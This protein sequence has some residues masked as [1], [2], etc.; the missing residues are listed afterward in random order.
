MTAVTLSE[1]FKKHH[2]LYEQLVNECSSVPEFKMTLDLYDKSL[3]KWDWIVFFNCLAKIPAEKSAMMFEDILNT[4]DSSDELNSVFTCKSVIL[5]LIS[6]TYSKIK[7]DSRQQLL[8]VLAHTFKKFPKLWTISWMW[9]KQH[10]MHATKLHKLMFI[11][12]SG[13]ESYDY[14]YNDFI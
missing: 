13:N 3:K 14:G 7:H 4:L 2:A 1:Y 8:N 12:K 11:T 6:L 5:N 10:C 9:S